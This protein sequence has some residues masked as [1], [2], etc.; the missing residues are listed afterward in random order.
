MTIDYH[1]RTFRGVANSA[2]GDV[3]SDTVFHYRQVGTSIWA[4]YEGDAVACGTM[5]GV[6]LGDGRL[7]LRYQHVTRDGVLRAGRCVSTPVVLDDG[8]IHLREAW[9]WTEGGSGSGASQVEEIQAERATVPA[10]RNRQTS[11]HYVWGAQCDG[12]RL[13]DRPDLEVTL[14]RMP[15]GTAEIPHVHR[16]ARQLF[17]VLN[18]RL[19]VDGPTGPLDVPA[20]SALE[21]PPGQ[22][23]AVQNPEDADATFLVVSAPSTQ[24]DRIDVPERPVRRVTRQSSHRDRHEHT[25]GRR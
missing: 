24:A 6:Q 20:E 23:H 2:T 12:W 7:D 15:P 22:V 19:R 18:G 4:T 25:H 17:F 11:E 13:L 5:V 9:T 21:V 8:R 1:N 14:E 16:R 10:T 3:G